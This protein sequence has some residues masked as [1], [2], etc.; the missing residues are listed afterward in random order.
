MEANNEPMIIA[1]K[2]RTPMT[3]EAKAA[4][5]AKRLKNKQD[6]A[7]AKALAEAEAKAQ[8][9]AWRTKDITIDDVLS[10]Y[11]EAEGVLHGIREQVDFA[12]DDVLQLLVYRHRQTYAFYLYGPERTKICAEFD[13]E[14]YAIVDNRNEVEH[15]WG[16]SVTKQHACIYIYTNSL[17]A[18]D[19][20]RA[21]LHK[22]FGHGGEMHDP[23]EDERVWN[24]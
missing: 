15:Y 12:G 4:M 6:Q 21:Y 13:M 24:D 1:R 14:A 17:T 18:Y 23:E 8:A 16:Y 10:K 3:D 5:V 7:E 9:R 20:W 11:T 2:P 19:C 22:K